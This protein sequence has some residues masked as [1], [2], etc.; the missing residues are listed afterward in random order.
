M[1]VCVCVC[2]CVSTLEI[3]HFILTDPA[4]YKQKLYIKVKPTTRFHQK[5]KH[6]RRC[7]NKWN[8]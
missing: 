3:R 7:L 5:P 8:V 6:F 4:Y 1:C 2:V